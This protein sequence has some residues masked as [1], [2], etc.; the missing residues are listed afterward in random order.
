MPFFRFQINKLFKALLALDLSDSRIPTNENAFLNYS[1]NLWSDRQVCSL[2]IPIMIGLDMWLHPCKIF[3]FLL[4][5][6]HF[7]NS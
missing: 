2:Q 6:M 3:L 5:F 4:S 1:N 7:S